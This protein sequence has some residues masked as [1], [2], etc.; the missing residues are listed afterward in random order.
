MLV[1]VAC[2]G[3]E[4]QDAPNSAQGTRTIEHAM[5]TAEVPQ[6]PERVVAL[7]YGALENVLA[8]DIQP[9][10]AGL[11]GNL[12]EQPD[13]I[14]KRLQGEIPGFKPGSPNLERL[15]ELNPDLIVGSQDW[16]AQ[17]YDQLSQIAPTVLTETN[18]REWQ[19]NL[20]FV[21]RVL[22]RSERAQTLLERYRER[23]ERFRA[24]SQTLV[25]LE[26]STARIFPNRVRL[27]LKDSFSGK[28]LQAAGLKRPPAQDKER[29]K[30]EISQEQ[31]ELL[32]GDVLFAMTLGEEAR[33]AFET[34]QSDP[35]WSQL[36]VVENERVYQVPGEYWVGSSILA[37]NEVID[38]LYRYLLDEEPAKSGI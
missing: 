32:E 23:I 18:N 3:S 35:V 37:A 5:G 20:Q 21:G 11:G 27:Y 13:Y 6:N 31:F 16:N 29:Y 28:I 26:V 15:L 10:G 1:F 30:K 36:S 25:G 7:E 12:S 9:V 2:S 17:I 24:E 19:A 14:Q 22:G 34:L 4:S 8:L 38:D 33:D